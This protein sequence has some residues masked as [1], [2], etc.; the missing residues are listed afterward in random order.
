MTAEPQIAAIAYQLCETTF[1]TFDAIK[2]DPVK[3]ALE[4]TALLLGK[5]VK[6]NTIWKQL[7]NQEW[8]E[9]IDVTDIFKRSSSASSSVVGR[10]GRSSFQSSTRSSCTIS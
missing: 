8:D 6:E 7:E 2:A 9:S 10:I 1:K 5:V 4:F 3:F